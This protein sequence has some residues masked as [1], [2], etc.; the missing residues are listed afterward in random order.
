VLRRCLVKKAIKRGQPL[1]QRRACP[2]GEGRANT[3]EL[4]PKLHRRAVSHE[5][6]DSVAS[7]EGVPRFGVCVGV[8]VFAAQLE[9][10][11]CVAAIFC[12]GDAVVDFEVVES[13]A[14]DADARSRR[15]MRSRISPQAQPVR[16]LRLTCQHCGQ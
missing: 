1:R 11:E 13:A 12:E 9:V 2:L 16:I 7:I 3:E 6:S 5:S 8:A 15:R 4:P 14:L 10:A